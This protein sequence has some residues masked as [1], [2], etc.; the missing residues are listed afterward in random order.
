MSKKEIISKLTQLLIEQDFK[1]KQKGKVECISKVAAYRSLIEFIKEYCD[2][3]E[4]PRGQE[5]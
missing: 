1:D 4:P 5:E 3:E 2:E